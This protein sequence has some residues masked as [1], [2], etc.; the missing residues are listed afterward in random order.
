MNWGQTAINIFNLFTKDETKEISGRVERD[1][2]A[3][4]D[5]ITDYLKAMQKAQTEEERAEIEMDVKHLK[6]SAKHLRVR[7]SVIVQGKMLS[8]MIRLGQVIFKT[9]V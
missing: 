1:Y 6:L 8:D 4:T 2:K 5:D 7:H 9:I 3:L